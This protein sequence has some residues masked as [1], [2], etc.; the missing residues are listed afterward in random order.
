MRGLGGGDGT[1][2]GGVR[3]GE[4]G[5]CLGRVGETG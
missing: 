4:T 2:W 3:V 5:Q 1:V